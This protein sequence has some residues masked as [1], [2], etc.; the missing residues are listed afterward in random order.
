MKPEV[1][2]V[3]H[4]PSSTFSY[5]VWDPETRHAAVI[6]PALDFDQN[7]GHTGTRTAQQL[8][9]IVRAEGLTVDWVLET[10]AHAD[11][12][13]AAPFVRDQVG[14][15]VAIGEGIRQVQEHFRDVFGLE[16]GFLP[17]GSQ[18]DHLFA[19]GETFEIGNIGARALATPGHT[20]DHMTYVIGD[21]AFVGDTLFMPDA[22]TAR[23]DFPGGDARKLYR[24][25]HKLFRELPD[26]TR[27]FMLHDYG[28]G[29]KRELRN[30]TTV[31][32]Q[33]RGNIHVHEGVDEDEYVRMRTERDATLDLPT[34]IIPSVQLNIRAGEMPPPDEHGHRYIKVPIDAF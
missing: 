20:N 6:D 4:E 31:G 8:V 19:D 34:L 28:A 17:D 5:V 2:H 29:G 24:S 16:R 3:L 15:R 11:H 13:T 10:H 14:G 30:E 32:A 7:S 27:M 22:G 26:E 12:V 23:C 18:W 33:R 21:A 1:R 9:D 25:V